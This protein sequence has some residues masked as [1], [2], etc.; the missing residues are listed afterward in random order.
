M[1]LSTQLTRGRTSLSTS[2][3]LTKLISKAFEAYNLHEG[4]DILS[5]V[6]VFPDVV[7]QTN[8]TDCDV[9]V[10]KYMEM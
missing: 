1:L 6:H 7:R 5:F 8:S 4:V 3:H 10:I 9:F 2:I